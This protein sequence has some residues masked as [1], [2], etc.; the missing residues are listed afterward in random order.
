VGR[1]WDRE[2][3]LVAVD[4]GGSGEGDEYVEEGVVAG[5]VEVRFH[6]SLFSFSSPST[7]TERVPPS[8]ARTAVHAPPWT[9]GGDSSHLFV[10]FHL[11]TL[12][13]PLVHRLNAL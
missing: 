1:A 12:P 6:L 4:K 3:E 9:Q 8:Q 11:S 2:G 5:G 7:A 13:V 10:V